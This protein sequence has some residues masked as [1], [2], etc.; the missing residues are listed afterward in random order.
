MLHRLCIVRFTG[1]PARMKKGLWRLGLLAC[2]SAIS[3][4]GGMAASRHLIDRELAD[5]TEILHRSAQAYEREQALV[6]QQWAESYA[7]LRR[8]IAAIPQSREAA[9]HGR[10]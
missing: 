2:L 10:R 9:Y 8:R 3:F 4:A 6:F 1:S 7:Q 5:S